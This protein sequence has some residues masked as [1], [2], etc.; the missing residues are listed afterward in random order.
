VSRTP[1]VRRPRT[2]ALGERI[3]SLAVLDGPAAAAV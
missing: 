2:Q 1:A 3:T